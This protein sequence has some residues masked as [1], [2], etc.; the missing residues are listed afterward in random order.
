[1]LNIQFLVDNSKIKHYLFKKQGIENVPQKLLLEA[2]KFKKIVELK[3]KVKE[4]IISAV[5]EKLTG[6]KLEGKFVVSILPPS[7]EIAQYNDEHNIEWGYSELYPNYIVIGLTHE[8]LH[9]L[10]HNFYTRLTDDQKWIFHSVIYLSIDEQLRFELNGKSEYFSAPIIET[11]HKRLI[12]TTKS[13]LPHFLK[14]ITETK[15]KNI[16]NFY[17]KI[18]KLKVK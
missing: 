16:F 4:P 2:E 13:I 11:Y 1:M 15:P 17:K 10:T 18:C 8:L 6:I 5:F 7:F 9:C 12:Q 3:W 14:Y